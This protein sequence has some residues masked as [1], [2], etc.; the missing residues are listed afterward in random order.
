[1]RVDGDP[2]VLEIS[3]AGPADALLI[4]HLPRIEG[5]IHQVD[6]VR[7]FLDGRAWDP[8]EAGV[9]AIVADPSARQLLRP[10]SAKSPQSTAHRSPGWNSS[11]SG[12]CSRLR[13]ICGNSEASTPSARGPYA[14]TAGTSARSRR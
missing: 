11:G 1:M 7:R 14:T 2:G 9:R 10:S 4:A 5:L 8:F 13:P 3:A 12:A 6:Q